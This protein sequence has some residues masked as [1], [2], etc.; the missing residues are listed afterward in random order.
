MVKS[1]LEKVAE[2]SS[3]IAGQIGRKPQ[4]AV[5]LGSGLGALADEVRQDRI[6]IPYSQ[7]PNFPVSRVEG[8]ENKLIFGKIYHKDVILLQGR[9]HYYEGYSLDDIT[10]PIRVLAFLGV[11]SIIMSNAA[12]GINK[13]FKPQD[14]MLITDHI[15]LSRTIPFKGTE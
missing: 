12:G 4:I 14:L 3:H 7:I 2:A 15:N 9:F 5:I 11:E 8:H 6:E 13:S 1:I 10:L